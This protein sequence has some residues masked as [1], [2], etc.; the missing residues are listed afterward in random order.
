[1]RLILL[2]IIILS[3]INGYSNGNDT[4]GQGKV[5]C[6]DSIFFDGYYVVLYTKDEVKDLER[7]RQR[8]IEGKSYK[9]PFESSMLKFFVSKDSI[10]T[11]DFAAIIDGLP[12]KDKK[13]VFIECTKDYAEALGEEFCIK[14]ESLSN[15][16]W[17]KFTS[18]NKYFTTKT[19]SKY[20]FK[21]YEISGW[22]V[23]LRVDTESKHDAIGKKI[24]YIDPH[25]KEFDAYFFLGYKTYSNGAASLKDKILL[26][27]EVPPIFE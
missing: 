23:K 20:C 25:S 27:K 17:P 16:L 15:C 21:I 7:S 13:E 2:P 8:R 14:K 10:A 4:T 11:R 12:K 22:F 18:D 26:W 5:S 9:A 24:R 1:M 3:V 19:K 6:A